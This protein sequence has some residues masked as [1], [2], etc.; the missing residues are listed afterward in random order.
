[1]EQRI[2]PRYDVQVAGDVTGV[3]GIIT[4][5]SSSGCRFESKMH[6]PHGWYGH[7][8]MVLPDHAVPLE[9]DLAV[10][11]WCNQMAMG[12]EFIRMRPD[13]QLVLR[14]FLARLQQSESSRAARMK[15]TVL[16]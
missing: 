13:Q 1:M 3:Q 8:Q 6:L 12:M 9:I 4:N 14:R 11:R 2:S 5:I 16:V 15:M 7:I 10:V